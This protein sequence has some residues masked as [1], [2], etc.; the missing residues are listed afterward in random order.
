MYIMSLKLSYCVTMMKTTRKTT[1]AT[2]TRRTEKNKINSTTRKKK[3]PQVF[4]LERGKTWHG[5]GNA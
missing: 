1:M 2:V 3:I 5:I 4:L